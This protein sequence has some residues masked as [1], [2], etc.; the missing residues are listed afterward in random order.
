[1]LIFSGIV[2]FFGGILGLIIGLILGWLLSI[3][4]NINEEEGDFIVISTGI[5]GIIGAL[6]TIG[7]IL[8]HIKNINTLEFLE[9]SDTLA[10]AGGIPLT[11]L[12]IAVIAILW[13]LGESDGAIREKKADEK[14]ETFWIISSRLMMVLGIGL[15]II[16]TGIIS[17]R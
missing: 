8:V 6:F 11:I 7:A 3:I 12:G 15:G 10:L 13:C 17:F 2:G 5:G 14:T 4:L 9:F 16:V 1:M